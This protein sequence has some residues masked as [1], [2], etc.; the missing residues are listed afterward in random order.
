MIPTNQPTPEFKIGV[1][2]PSRVG[3]TSLIASILADSSRFLGG[4]KVTLKP[5][6]TDTEIRIMNRRED[7]DGAVLAGH[8]DHVALAGTQEATRFDLALETGA[9][10]AG[11][12]LTLLDFPGGW[13]KAANRPPE[14]EEEWQKCREF[15][16]ESSVLLIPIDATVLMEASTP[17]HRRALPAT[18]NTA[19]VQSVAEDWATERLMRPDEPALVILVPVKCESYFADNGG[20]VAAGQVLLETVQ[21]VY[22]S[23][24]DVIRANDPNA[25]ILYCPVDTLGCVELRSAEWEPAPKAPGGLSFEARFSIRKPAKIS[26]RG[27]EDVLI[28]I[29]QLLTSA[30]R[31]TEQ[32]EVIRRQELALNAEVLARQPEGFLRSIWL[33][34]NGTTAA[35][36]DD[37]DDKSRLAEISRRRALLLA[38]AVDTLARRTY[39]DRVRRF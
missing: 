23:V 1:L 17:R 30:R 15:M 37:A 9:S 22:G 3:K 6:T 13:L 20:T 16:A 5:R 24:L 32:E 25:K 14:Q 35:R 19:E 8:F 4:T 12:R 39:S 28:A 38:E 7:L 34:A 21:Q 27:A 36:R 18:L 10:G 11:L 26:V 2:G 29:C 31:E 33:W